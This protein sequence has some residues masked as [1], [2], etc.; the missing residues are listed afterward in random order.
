MTDVAGMAVVDHGS[1]DIDITIKGY[2]QETGGP[3][4][5]CGEKL[6]TWGT[7][8]EATTDG[9]AGCWAKGPATIGGGRSD[10]LEAGAV[11]GGREAKRSGWELTGG[12]TGRQGR[13]A[14]G[15][16][17]KGGR[18]GADVGEEPPWRNWVTASES[19]T[20][21]MDM[22]LGGVTTSCATESK[23][24]PSHD[25]KRAAAGRERSNEWAGGPELRLPRKNLLTVTS[26][27]GKSK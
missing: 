25:C 19:Q 8:G 27:V 21:I 10:V 18:G 12:L 22:M 24:P 23:C 3:N 13:G 11:E 9:G 7:G 17:G 4:S 15:G 1:H 20:A 14:S 26:G 5:D 6:E 2:L 16:G